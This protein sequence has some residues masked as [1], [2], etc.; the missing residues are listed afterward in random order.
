VSIRVRSNHFR[1]RVEMEALT[2]ASITA[3]TIYD[4]LKPHAGN[5]C[6]SKMFAYWKRPVAIAIRACA[7]PVAAP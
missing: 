3:L 2:A 5:E 4:L 7:E 6:V 1:Y